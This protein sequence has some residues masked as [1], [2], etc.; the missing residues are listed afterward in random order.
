LGGSRTTRRKPSTVTVSSPDRPVAPAISLR[1]W[2]I[3]P[4]SLGNASSAS[5][6]TSLDVSPPEAPGEEGAATSTR[7]SISTRRGTTNGAV[8]GRCR[9]T[10]V[11]K[12]ANPSTV[13][14]IWCR[15]GVSGANRY[16]PRSS[17]VTRSASPPASIS[18][19][20]PGIA[21]PASSC[22]GTVQFAGI[23]P[24]GRALTGETERGPSS[25]AEDEANNE[26]IPHDG[27]GGRH[28]S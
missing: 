10:S 4:V 15:P 8:R 6:I 25:Y 16:C 22:T 27:K 23:L 7:S 21:P 12:G 18:T 5:P 2:T 3:P 24:R 11:A 26:A 20:A 17:V 19:S 9:S 1:V 13:T 28:R 14:R